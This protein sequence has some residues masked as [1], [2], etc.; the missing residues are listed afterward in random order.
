MRFLLKKYLSAEELKKI[1]ETIARVETT[2]SGEVRVSIRHKREWGEGKLSLHD[3]TLREF[4]RLGMQK[5]KDRTGVLLLL[6]LSER[7]FEIIADEGIH[8]KVEE[9]TWDRIAASMASHFKQGNFTQ[10]I[11]DAVDAV[12]NELG[13][14][15]PRE[16]GDRDELPNDVIER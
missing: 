9:G 14:H 15:F 1:S 8:K 2:T 16:A 4:H 3:L 5:T 7:K 11:C 13:K 10:G 12:G 6:L